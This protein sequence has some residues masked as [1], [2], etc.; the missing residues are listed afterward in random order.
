MLPSEPAAA[1][2]WYVDKLA[3]RSP[4]EVLTFTRKRRTARLADGM[5]LVAKSAIWNGFRL[6]SS[7]ASLAIAAARGTLML[8]EIAKL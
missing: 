5:M 4:D 8:P 2:A 7:V 1:G 3:R 6:G